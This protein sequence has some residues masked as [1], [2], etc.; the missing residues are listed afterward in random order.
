[1]SGKLG[2][3]A[4]NNGNFESAAGILVDWGTTN[5][6][7]FLVN[8]T[9]EVLETRQRPQGIRNV[10]DGKFPDTIRGIL[11]GWNST[12]PQSNQDHPN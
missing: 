8:S 6:R 11:K 10:T 2:E 1:M 7:A 5:L 9:G 12:C 3:V 4:M